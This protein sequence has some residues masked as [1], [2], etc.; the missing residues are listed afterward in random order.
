MTAAEVQVLVSVGEAEVRVDTFRVR[1][2]NEIT[3]AVSFPLAGSIV[4]LS[5]DADRF[6]AFVEQLSRFAETMPGKPS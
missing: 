6:L 1:A 4:T 2:A 3:V 5:F